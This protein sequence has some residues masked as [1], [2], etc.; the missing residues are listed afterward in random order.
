M[1]GQTAL[2]LATGKGEKGTRLPSLQAATGRAKD[3]TIL[4]T[5]NRTKG[6]PQE[7]QK[8]LDLIIRAYYLVSPI[9]SRH[10]A[11]RIFLGDQNAIEELNPQPELALLTSLR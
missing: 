9:P 1:Y 10:N 3:L 4:T 2:S 7:L 6:W 11:I 5:S 8:C